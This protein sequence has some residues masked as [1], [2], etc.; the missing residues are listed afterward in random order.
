M[1]N[2][3]LL[4][5]LLIPFL[6]LKAI[7]E[8][9]SDSTDVYLLTYTPGYELYNFFVHSAIRVKDPVHGLDLV[10]NYGTFDFSTP[11]FYLKFTRGKLLYQLSHSPFELEY[12][13]MGRVGHTVYQQKMN[14]SQAEKQNLYENLEKN[15]L[16]ENRYYKYDFI[17]DNCATRIR[18]IIE[19]SVQGKIVY[20]YGEKYQQERSF[21]ELIYPYIEDSEWISMGINL[22]FGNATDKIAK[23]YEYMFLP[24]YLMDI[25]SGAMILDDN[26]KREL[27]DEPVLIYQA[28]NHEDAQGA[29]LP[30]IIFWIAFVLVV[31]LSIREFKGKM[32]LKK[33]DIFLFGFS[34][35]LG[36][37]FMSLWLW[38]D[39]RALAG[40]LDLLWA[41]PLNL[42][43]PFYFR[44][45]QRKKWFSVYL[46]FLILLIIVYVF[47]VPMLFSYVIPLILLFLTRYVVNLL[48][49]W[50]K[51]R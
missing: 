45:W 42:V 33:L 11:N 9:L 40:N 14:L 1:K 46:I 50:V 48:E 34:G 37:F 30:A 25:F 44:R 24:Y 28:D 3:L 17:Y 19:V 10:Y 13:Q 4:I 35:F 41:F 8:P 32:S 15:Y 5:F 27:L 23:P 12:Y 6:S 51:R 2:S 43:V 22:L 7:D 39:H 47:A 21:R 38:S 26:G 20:N 49:R 36:V 16:P 29:S 18:D 31:F